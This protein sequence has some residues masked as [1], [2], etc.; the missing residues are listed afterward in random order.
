MS[1]TIDVILPDRIFTPSEKDRSHGS[2]LHLWTR[3][4]FET[5]LALARSIPSWSGSADGEVENML[6]Q[7]F[8]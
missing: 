7:A 6:F 2:T 1:N 8:S 4:A 5:A 3:V